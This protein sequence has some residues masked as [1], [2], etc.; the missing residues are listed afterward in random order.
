MLGLTYRFAP[1]VTFD[2]AAAALIVGDALNIQRTGGDLN[3]A[4]V[5]SG[6]PTCEAKNVYKGSARLRVTF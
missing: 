2:I 5:T 3:N 1:N 6:V 4:C